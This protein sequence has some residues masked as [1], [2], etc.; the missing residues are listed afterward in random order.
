MKKILPVILSIL[1]FT[2]V[3]VFVILRNPDNNKQLIQLS[4]KN[5][6]Y[7][8]KYG[9]TKIYDSKDVST[10]AYVTNIRVNETGGVS[11]PKIISNPKNSSKL[12]LS[13]NDFLIKENYA[14]IFV[15]DDAGADWKQKEIPLSPKF[16]QSTYSDPWIDYDTEG[17]IFFVA[18]Q[19]DALENGREAICLAVSY[20]DGN[21]WRNDFNFVDHNNKENIHMDRPKIYVEKNSRG[22]NSIYV[23]WLEIKGIKTFIMF[24]KSTDGGN[25]FTP[26]VSI[27]RNRVEF[28]S[29]TS[30]SNGELFLVYFKDEDNISIRKSADGG[31]HW[32]K[33]FSTHY[34]DPSGSISE[35]QYLI[36]TPSGKGIRINSEPAIVNS[37]SDD[38]LMTYSAAGE[39]S[40]LS[41][42]YFTR[43]KKNSMEFTTPVRVHSDRTLNDQF[44]PS[45]TVDGSD[46]IYVLYQDSRNDSNNIFTETY[47]SVSTDGGLTFMD[48]KLSTKNFNPCLVA[49]DGYIGDYNSCIVSD[50]KLIGVWTDGRNNNLDL[51]TGMFDVNEFI[52]NKNH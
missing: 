43:L 37:K 9:E 26:P 22:K 47:V 27:D 30:N 24:S 41:D 1:I 40:D 5:Y 3:F 33:T 35:D 25:T 46:N 51:Y 21:T 7:K 15:S 32:G 2:S 14:R 52:K 49:I 39:D 16:K 31:D 11:E 4:P 29:M 44:L 36:K 19:T 17:N 18:I 13:A 8:D 12:A 45:I 34:F 48:Q 6:L 38:L 42:V 23:S 10:E 50:D 28:C 20:D